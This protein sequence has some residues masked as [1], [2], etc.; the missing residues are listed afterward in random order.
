MMTSGPHPHNAVALTLQT[1]SENA[2]KKEH[3]LEPFHKHNIGGKQ[4]AKRPIFAG[5]N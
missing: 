5:N 1:N 2:K 4:K 3:N